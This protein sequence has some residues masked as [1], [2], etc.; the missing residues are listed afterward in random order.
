MICVYVHKFYSIYMYI[1]II[2]LLILIKSTMKSGLQ[3]KKLMILQFWRSKVQNVSHG[4]KIC[5]NR[6]VFLSEA[7]RRESIFLHF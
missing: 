5:V 2:F 6:T 7:S 4:A 1:R 3:Q